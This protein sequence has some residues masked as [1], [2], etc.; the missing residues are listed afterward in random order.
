MSTLETE[1]L[2]ISAGDLSAMGI[3]ENLIPIVMDRCT[4]AIRNGYV[5]NDIDHAMQFV[6]W[7]FGT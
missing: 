7:Y 5:E 1:P 4:F 3:S 2:A 6:L